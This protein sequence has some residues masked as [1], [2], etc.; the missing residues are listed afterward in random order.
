MDPAEEFQS[1]LIAGQHE[2]H[3]PGQNDDDG[4]NDLVDHNASLFLVT[5]VNEVVAR[6]IYGNLDDS[7]DDVSGTTAA[8]R[9][10]ENELEI[11]NL[12]IIFYQPVNAA[13][14][15]TSNLNNT[16]TPPPGSPTT[17][18]HDGDT[19]IPKGQS[20][21][22]FLFRDNKVVFLP[23]DIETGRECCGIL[24]L[25]AE[26]V[27]VELAPKTTA[28]GVISTLNDTAANV[29]REPATFNS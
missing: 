8:N 7:P 23:F 1:D 3:E 10:A 5:L 16:P 15:S 26:I 25:S 19:N 18:L 21:A 11:G 12:S 27:W 20:I 6:D 9:L 4:H 14:N 22:H 17:P 29:R 13:G 24:Q 28:K 2:Q